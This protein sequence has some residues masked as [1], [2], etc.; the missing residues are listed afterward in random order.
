VLLE[1]SG[2]TA[3]EGTERSRSENNAQLWMH[4]LLKVKFNAVKNNIA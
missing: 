3:P 2:E 4:L 1:A